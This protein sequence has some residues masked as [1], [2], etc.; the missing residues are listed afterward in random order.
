MENKISLSDIWREG[1]LLFGG[2]VAL[3]GVIE[4]NI[5]KPFKDVNHKVNN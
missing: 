2:K 4:E 5:S 3:Y 1:Y